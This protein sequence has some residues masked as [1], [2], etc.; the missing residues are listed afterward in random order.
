MS[1]LLYGSI[2]ARCV[3]QYLFGNVE[4]K[5]GFIITMSMRWLPV[6]EKSYSVN[7]ESWHCSSWVAWR[8]TEACA[9][10]GLREE[11]DNTKQK[12]QA[13]IATCSGIPCSLTTGSWGYWS[14]PLYFIN[15]SPLCRRTSLHLLQRPLRISSVNARRWALRAAPR[16]ALSWPIPSLAATMV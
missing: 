7:D 5:P 15:F 10:T 4:E 12:A 14:M 3:D 11:L 2:N 6:I 9:L 13:L 16:R 8:S 1:T